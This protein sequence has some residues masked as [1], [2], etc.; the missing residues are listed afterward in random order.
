MITK[1]C[2]RLVRSVN[3]EEPLAYCRVLD[4]SNADLCKPSVTERL[5]L[6]SNKKIKNK[7]YKIKN[8]GRSPHFLL[9]R[10]HCLNASMPG[11]DKRRD[12]PVS[13]FFNLA[14]VI[15]LIAAEGI[16][17]EANA[18]IDGLDTTNNDIAIHAIA[19]LL[20]AHQRGR[21]CG[22]VV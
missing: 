9:M 12:I 4:N 18:W 20:N 22:A 8:R 15:P 6:W 10:I 13:V 2:K 21:K 16:A 14:L 17:K 19:V 11:P 3:V 7:K 5:H 1:T